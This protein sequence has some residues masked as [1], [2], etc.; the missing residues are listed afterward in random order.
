[1]VIRGDAP[2]F[3]QT[4]SVM[5]RLIVLLEAGAAPATANSV[6]DTLMAKLTGFVLQE[7]VQAL[8]A[9]SPPTP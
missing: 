4:P 8:T 2:G 6:A 7:Q 1:M 3:A 9:S 5:G